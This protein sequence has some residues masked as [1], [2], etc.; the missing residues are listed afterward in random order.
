MDGTF[1]SGGDPTAINLI[2]GISP[3]DEWESVTLHEERG[4]NGE[5]SASFMN[6]PEDVGPT[7]THVGNNVTMLMPDIVAFHELSHAWRHLN[8][9]AASADTKD[10]VTV[11]VDVEG[12][13]HPHRVALDEA[14]T[15]G[16]PL[17]LMAALGY[18]VGADGR[19]AIKPDPRV[20]EAIRVASEREAAL[21]RE[22]GPSPD[23]LVAPITTARTL[24]Q[25]MTEHLYVTDRGMPTRET[26]PILRGSTGE[27]FSFGLADESVAFFEDMLN[28]YQP[29]DVT[30][31]WGS[32]WLKKKAPA[33]GD[34]ACGSGMRAVCES[35]G[36]DGPLS[37]GS[38]KVLEDY[39]TATGAG[40]PILSTSSGGPVLSPSTAASFSVKEL[41]V[42]AKGQFDLTVRTMGSFGRAGES[43]KTFVA[44]PQ[45]RELLNRMDLH[46][47]S[48]SGKALDGLDVVDW[49]KSVKGAFGADVSNLQTAATMTAMV[50]L[51]AESLGLAAA[52]QAG[53]KLGIAANVLA[54]LTSIAS[55]F[56]TNP[57]VGIMVGLIGMLIVSFMYAFSAPDPSPVAVQYLKEHR[58]KAFAELVPQLAKDFTHVVSEAFALSQAQQLVALGMTDA[59][60]DRAAEQAAIAEPVDGWS[61]AEEAATTKAELHAQLQTSLTAQKAGLTASMKTAFRELVTAE[62]AD[63]ATQKLVTNEVL[64][65]FEHPGGGYAWANP[66]GSVTAGWEYFV[67]VA[68]SNQ[69]WA[70]LNGRIPGGTKRTAAD[71]AAG[72]DL[73]D[74]PDTIYVMNTRYVPNVKTLYSTRLTVP[75]AAVLDQAIDTGLQ[76]ATTMRNLTALTVP[77]PVTT[78][79]DRPWRL[80]RPLVGAPATIEGTPK[81]IPGLLNGHG[82]AGHTIQ[83]RDQDAHAHCTTKVNT[84]GTWGCITS[85]LIAPGA[86]LSLWEGDVSLG[87]STTVAGTPLTI[88]APDPNAVAP[89]GTVTLRGTGTS[90]HP[91][92]LTLHHPAGDQPAATDLGV[93]TGGGAAPKV[94]ADGTWSYTIPS[95][96]LL[97][98]RTYSVSVADKSVYEHRSVT[99]TTT[100]TRP[101][102]PTIP[103]EATYEAETTATGGTV[104]ALSNGQQARKYS[105]DEESSIPVTVPAAGQ[106]AVTITYSAASRG[107]NTL[108]SVYPNNSSITVQRTAITSSATRAIV[109]LTL[110]AGA[111]SITLVPPPGKQLPDIDRLT[112]IGP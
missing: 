75:S 107:N 97:P 26:Y 91:L 99:F 82:K 53:D 49:L 65:L 77:G 96:T 87:V 13:P 40:K 5:G 10:D 35:T 72:A 63:P 92:T 41:L 21:L 37:D 111:N 8:G 80:V 20:A 109:S 103:F 85:D 31:P 12:K 22:H 70:C 2:M 64:P 34:A 55:F 29:N 106:Y 56:I 102:A 101:S 59:A 33:G 52:V 47:H 83:V 11:T 28:G 15:T 45:T 27:V 51:F 16:S 38:A 23:G 90:G 84:Y 98:G 9:Y 30:D 66:D 89:D 67:A 43:G 19:I 39:R 25:G 86:T 50:P 7:T 61:Y 6:V 17:L 14:L 69:E 57:T 88:A 44:M 48:A 18:D 36:W 58:D 68:E 100:G 24:G 112:L 79:K 78:V 4:R 1:S 95:G 3:K 74:C 104:F 93:S 105:A 60:I 42:L 94:A 71:F 46:L 73:S 54:L 108:L 62:A 81:P 32:A 110:K 76:A